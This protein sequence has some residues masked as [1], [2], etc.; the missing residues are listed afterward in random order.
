MFSSAICRGLHWHHTVCSKAVSGDSIK[1]IMSFLSEFFSF[2][3][4]RRKLDRPAL[5]IKSKTK[6]FCACKY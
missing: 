3:S 1:T 5:Y 6:L 2:D 4:E